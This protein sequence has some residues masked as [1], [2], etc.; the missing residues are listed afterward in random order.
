MNEHTPQVLDYLAHGNLHVVGMIPWSSNQALLVVVSAGD[1]EVQAIYKPGAAE[2]P[3]WDFPA[4]TLF[5]REI[6]AYRLAQDLGWGFV[7][8]TVWRRGPY[9]PGSLQLFIDYDAEAHYFT[10]YPRHADDFRRLALFDCIANNADRKSGHCLLDAQDRLW[11]IDHGLCFHEEDKLRTVIW[12]FAGQPVPPAMLTD[13]R[14]L[15]A[16]WQ[17]VAHVHAHYGDLLSKGEI[18][19]MQ[20]RLQALLAA[21]RFPVPDPDRRTVPWPPI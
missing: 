21:G 15:A 16:R 5:M 3:L 19:A 7:P 9:G 6:A 18:A 17:D 20:A 10:I 4:G 12:E 11:A 8:P 13:L 1:E 2:R 14:A